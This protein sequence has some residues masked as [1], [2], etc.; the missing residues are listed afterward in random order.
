MNSAAKFSF[1]PISNENCEILI[2][3]SLPGERSLEMQQYYGHAQNRFWKIISALINT[4]IPT[5]YEDKKKLLVENKIAVWDVV[6]E[7]KRQG[8]LD[9]NIV[10]EIPNDLESFIENHKNLRIIAFNGSKSQ[11]LFDRYF[12]RK[13]NLTYLHLPSTSPANANYNFERLINSWKTI[14]IN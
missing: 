6:R 4:E 12:K 9:T 7:A 8:S 13:P 11:K 1:P 2:L 3:G 5:N 10:G 14:F